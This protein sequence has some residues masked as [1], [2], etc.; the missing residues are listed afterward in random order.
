[1][2]DLEDELWEQI[3]NLHAKIANDKFESRMWCYHVGMKDALVELL[4]HL[5]ERESEGES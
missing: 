3:H 5:R 2:T 1:M 4:E